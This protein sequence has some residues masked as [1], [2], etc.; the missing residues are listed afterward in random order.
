MEERGAYLIFLKSWADMAVFFNI[1]S[2]RLK[3]HK[4]FRTEQCTNLILHDESYTS[5]AVSLLIHKMGQGK[6]V[7]I[8]GGTF[9]NFSWI[10]EA[11][12]SKGVLIRGG[13]VGR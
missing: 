4:L 13:W 8:R 12:I 2:A 10:G 11:L 3:Q 1:S 7:L 6:R 9:S 5:F